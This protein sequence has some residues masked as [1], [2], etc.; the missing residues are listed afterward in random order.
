MTTKL[1]AF[2]L[3][4]LM[5]VLAIIGVLMLVAMPV[6][7]SLFGDAY[8]IE[9][10]NQLS[11]LYGRQ[12]SYHQQYFGYSEDPRKIGF[13]S[14]KTV[15]EDGTARYV[16]E[17]VEASKNSFLAR[18]TAIADFDGDGNINV[19]EIDQEGRPIEVVPD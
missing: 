17:V 10:K 9:A 12:R 14:P 4:E 18:A 19:W 5:T 16:Y 3:T 15:D 7:D 8:S 13:T 2:T 1:P 6:F 11:Y